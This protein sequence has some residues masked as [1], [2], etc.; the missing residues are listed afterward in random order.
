[1]KKTIV[2]I[3]FFVLLL[4]ALAACGGGTADESQEAPAE[5]VESEEETLEEEAP[6][7]EEAIE[8]EPPLAIGSE[9]DSGA[10]PPPINS[11]SKTST[12]PTNEESLPADI[13]FIIKLGDDTA[14]SVEELTENWEDTA[15]QLNALPNQ[16]D[17]RFATILLNE[18]V[19]TQVNSTDFAPTLDWAAIV[20]DTTTQTTNSISESAVDLSWQEEDTLQIVLILADLSAFDIQEYIFA[21]TAVYFPI[22][23]PNMNTTE[24]ELLDLEASMEAI[25]GHLIQLKNS[26][27]TTL[28]E[29]IILAIAETL[30]PPSE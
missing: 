3:I 9:D 28:S 12:N 25:N 22:I 27:Q 15:Q 2:V 26:D 13:L 10:L 30:T 23:T 11:G 18:E 4:L 14:V 1:M 7:E 16:P 8:E 20:E 24:A 17:L 21:E 5:E 19:N 29:Q 6:A